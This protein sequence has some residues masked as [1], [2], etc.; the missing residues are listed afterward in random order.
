MAP[1]AIRIPKKQDRVTAQAHDGVYIVVDVDEAAKTV[2]LQ[3]VTGNGPVIAGVPWTTLGYMA[4][5]N[6]G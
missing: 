3:T 5:E 1:G 4:E 6:A 2:S